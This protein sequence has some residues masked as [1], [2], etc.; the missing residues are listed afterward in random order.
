[1]R[2]WHIVRMRLRS[3]IRRR[4]YASELDEELRLHVAREAE[5]MEA[6]GVSPREA[7]R[8]ALRDLGGLEQAKE[9]CREARGIA[10]LEDVARDVR[11]AWRSIVR[12]PVLAT[13]VVGSLAAGVGL[14]TAVFSWIEAFVL[15]PLPGVADPSGFHLVEPR[16]ASGLYPGVSWPEY[17]DLDVR[18]SSI[19][20]LLAFRMVPLYLGGPGENQRSFG[21]LVS[22]NYFPGLGLR[23]ALGRFPEPGSA[24][25]D[26]EVVISYGLW[27]TRF[28]GDAGAVGR[29]LEVNGVELAITGVAPEGFQGTI[30]GL[31]FDLWVPAAL[32]PRLFSGS[33]ELVERGQ[34]G[35]SAMGRLAPGVTTGQAQAELDAVMYR[36]ARDYPET[37]STIGGEVLP[38]WRA[39]RGPQGMLLGSL[40]VLQGVMLLLLLAV[41]GNTA[42][43]LL[44]R[45][46][47]RDREVGIRLAMGAGPR[48]IARLLMTEN[49]LLGLMGAGL[50]VLIAVWGTN[51]LRAVPVYTLLPVRFQTAVDSVG[52][53]FAVL[54]GLGCA[55]AFGAAPVLQLVRR[56]PHERLRPVSAAAGQSRLRNALMGVEAA[57]A[58]MVLIAA[59]LFLG[60]F[61]D[62]QVLD[63]GFGRE[64][65]LLAAYDLSGGG[66][67]LARG[68]VVDPALARTFTRDLL[69]ALRATPQVRAAAVAAAVPLD[70][71]GLPQR[72]FVLEGRGR[73]GP[74]PDRALTNDV[75]PGY[76]ETM[77]IALVDGSDFADLDDPGPAP[78]AIVNE[79]FVRRYLE[80]AG[81][82]GRRLEIDGRD[83]V[84]T[85]VAGNSTYN[86]FGEPPL[87]M[88]YLSYRD[89]T[90]S[91]GQIHLR[92][93]AG[94]ETLMA[95]EIRRAVAGLGGAVP[96]YDVRTMTDHVEMNLFL[97]RIPAR[98]FVVLGPLLLLL[99]AIGI[100]AV[101]AYSVARRTR[102]IGIRIA[103]GARAGTVVAGIVR[104]SM[105][106]IV[107]GVLAGCL[108]ALFVYTHLLRGGPIDWAVFAGVPLLLLLI[109]GLACWLPAW[110]AAR[111]DPMASLRLE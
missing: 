100:Y 79:E 12:M 96:V 15:A 60:S 40:V 8:L 71:H 77:G 10:F 65:V 90:R 80:G 37:N 41:C 74:A 26:A 58:V 1:M 36:L 111:V 32:A 106:L 9:A 55:V 93:E 7:R 75:T 72:S 110:R 98:I 43:L 68:G 34:R 27:Q 18:L 94:A 95:N 88:I 3:L 63:P 20:E 108:V 33:R 62:T 52:L 24:A 13:V 105:A 86:A 35:Y 84:I 56:H 64:G 102:E 30:L 99:A 51:A 19:P 2:I 69:D 48:R 42:N 22:E 11:H 78:Q 14:N 92:T 97:K 31:D 28:G 57:L 44:A 45:A 21:L 49:L 16:D 73:R 47:T 53:A 29:T 81:P 107:Y 39:P 89:R 66:G 109:A 38:F 101:V 25:P 91:F 85:G 23:P 83:Y 4:R 104:E 46:T 87:P 17:E 59:A 5:R 76:F 61:R 82:L 50:G 67:H 54:L 6:G 103:L 70:I